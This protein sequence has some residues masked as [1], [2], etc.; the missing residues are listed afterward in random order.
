[1]VYNYELAMEGGEELMKATLHRVNEVDLHW[2]D[3]M[4]IIFVLEGSV[5]V[6][7]GKDTYCLKE[8]DL[9]LINANELHG[10][11]SNNEKNLLLSLEINLEFYKHCF[12]KF[13]NMMFNCKDIFQEKQEKE[14]FYIIKHY[15]ANIMWC[16]NKRNRGYELIVGSYLYL[17]GEHLL[18]NFYYTVIED[19][20]NEVTDKDFIRIRNIIDYTKANMGRNVTLKEVAEEQHLSYHFLSHFIK[21]KIGI[22]FQ[23]YLNSIRLNKAV[24][25]LVN[26]DDTITNIAYVSGF[27][28]LNFFNGVFKKEYNC[29]PREYR[30]RLSKSNYEG[31]KFGND[32]INLE[33]RKKFETFSYVDKDA[34]LKK[35]YCYLSIDS[36]V[37]SPMDTDLQVGYKDKVQVPVH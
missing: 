24:N 8:N 14:K 16:L 7:L 21:D 10:T 36:E 37:K 13:K 2:H 26:S 12:P 31:V 17:L 4:E 34:A 30:Q 9:I 3:R 5:N 28:S 1:M 15:I 32:K 29:S 27:S 20:G 23:E 18:N 35:L 25:M 11:R 6:K 19:K 22:S 33:H